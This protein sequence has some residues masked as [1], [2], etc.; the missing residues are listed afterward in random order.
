M[1]SSLKIIKKKTVFKTISTRI[2]NDLLTGER[3]LLVYRK[4]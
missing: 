1:K 2:V 3:K 4:I